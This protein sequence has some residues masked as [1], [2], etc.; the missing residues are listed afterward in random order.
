MIEVGF[1]VFRVSRRFRRFRRRFFTEKEKSAASAQSMG[2]KNAQ[3]TGEN[4][5]TNADRRGQPFACLLFFGNFNTAKTPN[6]P[7]KICTGG[8]TLKKS[9]GEMQLGRQKKE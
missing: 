4:C 7:A 5:Q 8:K 2:G 3:S 6:H 9:R 1:F